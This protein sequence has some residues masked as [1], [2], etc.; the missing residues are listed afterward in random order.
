VDFAKPVR[1][2]ARLI[3]WAAGEGEAALG[4]KAHVSRFCAALIK[5]LSGYEAEETPSDKG[6][7]VTGDILAR[8]VSRILETHNTSLEPG[9]R[10]H[11]EADLIGS[12]AFH[13]ET[14]PPHRIVP[15]TSSLWS[16]GPEVR[17]LIKEWGVA[18]DLPEKALEELA[19][20]LEAENLEVEGLQKEA[21]HW[22]QRYDELK[23]GLEAEPDSALAQRAR[24][25]LD[26]GKL[27]EAGAAC[28]ELLR[29][30]KARRDA[31]NERIAR[32][33]LN[34]GLIFHLEFKPLEALPCYAEAYSLRQSDPDYA[35]PY[36]VVL[37]DQGDDRHAEAVLGRLRE[38]LVS[39]PDRY[40]DK[41]A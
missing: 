33:S 39:E 40:R 21:K 30:A 1:G 38:Q 12:Q 26:D 37:L 41:L 28:D 23:R 22:K 8:S 35:L 11:V 18:D 34:R 24:S 25:L 36:A 31:E 9:K 10:Q 7:V 14:R 19:E 6:W 20:R 27:Q 4:V 32:Y 16:V 2:F 3:L 13:F 17:P 29:A 5:A 15:G